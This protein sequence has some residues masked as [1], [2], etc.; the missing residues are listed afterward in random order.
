MTLSSAPQISSVP[1]HGDV[2]A[3]FLAMCQYTGVAPGE[4]L[5]TN[6]ESETFS[7]GHY[8]VYDRKLNAVVV[9]IRGTWSVIDSVA[10]LLAK[11]VPFAFGGV[12]GC[13]HEGVL[14]CAEKKYAALEPLFH[15][16]DPTLRLIFTGHS[17]GGGIATLLALMAVTQHPDLRV[18]CVAFAPAPSLTLPLATHPRVRDLVTSFVLQDD[19]VPRLSLGSMA[20]AKAIVQNLLLQGGSTTERLMQCAAGGNVFRSYTKS[21]LGVRSEV[22]IMTAINAA[23]A[24]TSDANADTF[25]YPAGRIFY[26][27]VENNDED[28][29]DNDSNN[30]SGSDDGSSNSNSNSNSDCNSM[31]GGCVSC[32]VPILPTATAVISN[33]NNTER[34]DTLCGEDDDEALSKMIRK[35]DFYDGSDVSVKL[36]PGPLT[37]VHSGDMGS[38]ISFDLISTTQQQQDS[39]SEQQHPQKQEKEEDEA[40]AKKKL[41]S[42]EDWKTLLRWGEPRDPML[43]SLVEIC[44]DSMDYFNELVF[45]KRLWFDH[46]PFRYDEGLCSAL[47]K[48]T[49]V[50]HCM[51]TPIKIETI[52]QRAREEPIEMALIVDKQTSHEATPSAERLSEKT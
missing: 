9:S 46:M 26:L 38:A 35:G 1:K 10:D 24:S 52:V 14:R 4:V 12:E 33:N 29:G 28:N 41:R 19:A 22:D 51:S 40:K 31:Y 50:Q 6:W 11:G 25:M 47:T 15:D 44:T 37:P 8:V 39:A 21:K 23:R 18:S 34:P 5:E 13:A 49:G 2:V 17:L 48:I 36:S 32:P 7:T 3:N 30:N 16:F 27:T 45:S 43:C 20:R 42:N